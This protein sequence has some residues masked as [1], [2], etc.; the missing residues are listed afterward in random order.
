MEFDLLNR[1]KDWG[2]FLKKFLKSPTQVA[3]VF[4][5]SPFL[6]EAMLSGIDW[7][8]GEVLVEFGPGTGALTAAIARQFT[9]DKRFLGIERD[10]DFH[11]L[12]IKKYPDLSFHMGSAEDLSEILKKHQ[13]D[14]PKYIVSSLPFVTMPDDV[15]KTVLESAARNLKKDGVFVTFTYLHAMVLPGGYRLRQLLKENF[16]S[17]ELGPLVVTNL[18]P[19]FVIRARPKG[20]S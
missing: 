5:S 9:P 3:S 12:L 2:L 17:F 20:K 8:S 15:V 10:G 1:A 7:K 18:P 4:P 14:Q 16:G 6:A 13:L 11:Q 19:A